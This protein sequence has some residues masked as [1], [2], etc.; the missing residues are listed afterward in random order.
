MKLEEIVA[1]VLT[2]PI[3]LIGIYVF[4]LSYHQAN[5][6]IRWIYYI[7]TGILWVFSAIVLVSKIEGSK[8][9]T[10]PQKSKTG[11]KEIKGK[12]K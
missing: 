1:K 11:Q 5:I 6:I 2:V 7:M 9:E 10:E 4:L 8:K 12:N 3:I